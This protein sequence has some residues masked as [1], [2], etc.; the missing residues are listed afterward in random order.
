[1]G[2]A[3]C[4]SS[5]S[6][7]GKSQVWAEYSYGTLSADLPAGVRVPAVVAAAESSL[8]QRGYSVA[9]RR[10][11]AEEGA[12]EGKAS[13]GG[14]GDDVDVGVRAVNA[15]TRVRVRV[16]LVGDEARSRGILDDVMRRLGY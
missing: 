3:G 7:V 16:G 6:E 5:Y 4:R 14:V 10:A 13:A 12:V 1:M 15:A 9:S 8:K 2:C 11:T